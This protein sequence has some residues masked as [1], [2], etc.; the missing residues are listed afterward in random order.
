MGRR[1]YPR[2]KTLQKIDTKVSANYT[3][4]MDNLVEEWKNKSREWENKY[5]ALANSRPYEA[6]MFKVPREFDHIRL[7]FK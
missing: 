3:N 7:E 1:G 4:M 2:R 6:K 5:H